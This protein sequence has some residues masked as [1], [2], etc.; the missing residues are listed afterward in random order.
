LNPCGLFLKFEKKKAYMEGQ[1]S[2][3]SQ[4]AAYIGLALPDV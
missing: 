3:N 1:I 4:E 2:K